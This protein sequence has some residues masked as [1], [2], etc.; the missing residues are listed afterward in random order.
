MHQNPTSRRA[1]F[2][3]V[4][5]LVVIL[6][7]SILLTIGAAGFKNAGGKGVSTALAATEALFDE[8]RS[9]AVGKGTRARVLIDINDVNSED[10]YLRRMVVAFEEIDEDGNPKENDWA[11]AGKGYIFPAKTF[12][13]QEYSNKDHKSGAGTLDEMNLTGV[14]GLYDGRWIYYEFNS[15]GICT[16]GLGGS[17]DYSAPSFVI[18]NG[19]RG[20]GQENPRT[21][22]DGRRDFAGFVI[23]RNG[24]TSI[25][26]NPN[27]ILGGEKPST[28]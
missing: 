12:F 23:Q 8:A 13:S 22:S 25:F 4:E 16:T 10:T 26:R 20:R 21:T 17:G 3:L 28:F 24:A 14:A 6:I 2:T 18:G 15:E 27:Q 11:L 5:L 1:G 19:A 9:I 7:I